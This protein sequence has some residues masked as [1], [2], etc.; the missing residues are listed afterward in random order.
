MKEKVKKKKQ[1]WVWELLISNTEQMP[2][3]AHSAKFIIPAFLYQII[4]NE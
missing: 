1:Q 3:W 2:G 4:V